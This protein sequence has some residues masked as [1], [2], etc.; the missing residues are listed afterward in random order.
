MLKLIGSR[1]RWNHYYNTTLRFLH[2]SSTPT[3]TLFLRI[4]RAGDPII[5]M[6]PILNQWIQEGRDVNHSELQ[7]FIKQ[8]RT[9]RRF[10][11]ALQVLS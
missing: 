7:F 3:D 10:K 6:T 5:P 11:Q 8:L 4:S 9:R 2:S 1:S